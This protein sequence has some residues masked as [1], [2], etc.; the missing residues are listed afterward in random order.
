M[1]LVY[2]VKNVNLIG[3]SALRKIINDNTYID[4]LALNIVDFVVEYRSNTLEYIL[5]VLS[6]NII[7]RRF[8]LLEDLLELIDH[9]SADCEFLSPNYICTS[10]KTDVEEV[11]KD[12]ILKQAQQ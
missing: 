12:R 7:I 6:N 3:S 10:D 5:S 11:L 9:Y 1:E 8:I 4:D 2:K